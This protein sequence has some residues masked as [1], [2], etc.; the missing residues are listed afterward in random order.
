MLKNSISKNLQ[1]PVVPV[2]TNGQLQSPAR[3]GLNTGECSEL[4]AE[5]VMHGV[6]SPEDPAFRLEQWIRATPKRP[7]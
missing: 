6:P 4:L 2:A 1:V 3:A 5:L 7:D